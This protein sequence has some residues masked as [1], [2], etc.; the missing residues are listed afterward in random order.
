[1]SF[2]RNKGWSCVLIERFAGG[3]KEESGWRIYLRG[4]LIEPLERRYENETT[5]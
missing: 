5:D 1:M 4:V 3:R 2:R